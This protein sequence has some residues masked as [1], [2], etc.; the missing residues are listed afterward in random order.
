M[1][2]D[3]PK[4]IRKIPDNYNHDYSHSTSSTRRSI[5]SQNHSS[6]RNRSE[7]GS[8]TP[9]QKGNEWI[10]NTGADSMWGQTKGNETNATINQSQKE[11]FEK[12]QGCYHYNFIPS[13]SELAALNPLEDTVEGMAKKIEQRLMP[14]KR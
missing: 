11:Y 3:G 8:G 4:D 2:L 12:I 14:L 9:S 13:M 5:A 10:N 7:W 1:S 6:N